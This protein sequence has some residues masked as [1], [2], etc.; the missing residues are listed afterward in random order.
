[1]NRSYLI[2]NV[3]EIHLVDFSCVCESS[4][5]TLRRS[6]DRTKTF[7]KWEDCNGTPDF[8]KNLTTAEGPYTHTEILDILYTSDW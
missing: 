1:M 4:P 2:F 5:E 3:S 6:I 7:V 8:V